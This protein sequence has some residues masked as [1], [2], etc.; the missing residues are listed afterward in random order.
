MCSSASQVSSSK[1]VTSDLA[2]IFSDDQ[3]ASPQSSSSSEVI[4]QKSEASRSKSSERGKETVVVM[5]S[6]KPLQGGDGEPNIGQPGADL[7][8]T[9]RSID[10]VDPPEKKTSRKGSEKGKETGVAM[11]SYKPLQGLPQPSAPNIG[12]QGADLRRTDR[13]I[14]VAVD[15]PEEKTS[16]KSSEKGKETGVVM[17]SYKPLQGS[18]GEPKIDQ[19]ETVLRRTDRS[20]TRPAR[21]VSR[22]AP[23]PPEKDA[24]QKRSLNGDSAK[25]GI[26]KSESKRR[27]SFLGDG[28][29]TSMSEESLS[30]LATG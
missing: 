22:P 25:P 20:I 6:Y 3:P 5:R 29:H 30:E 7:R 14:D 15:L 1:S 21:P 26:V 10:M 9:D 4:P 8:R 2:L 12:Q 27:L 16:R 24:T 23:P 28:L 19:P 18:D 17:H 11:L 13:S